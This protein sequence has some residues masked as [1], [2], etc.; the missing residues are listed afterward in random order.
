V[1][2][3]TIGGLSTVGGAEQATIELHTNPTAGYFSAAPA[4]L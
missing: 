4:G 1:E 3:D 2:Y